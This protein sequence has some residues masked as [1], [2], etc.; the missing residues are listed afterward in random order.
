MYVTLTS[1]LA[2]RGVARHAT[3]ER[4]SAMESQWQVHQVDDIHPAAQ[5]PCL[6]VPAVGA[7]CGR[8]THCQVQ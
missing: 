2:V 8:E 7:H 4:L 5:I 3:I 6:L 1:Y